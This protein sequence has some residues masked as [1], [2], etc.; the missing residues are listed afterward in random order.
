[1]PRDK[2]TARAYARPTR[3]IKRKASQKLWTMPDSFVCSGFP[4]FCCSR[5]RL[6]QPQMERTLPVKVIIG[7]MEQEHGTV[8]RSPRGLMYS[9]WNPEHV[10]KQVELKS[11]WY[12]RAD[13]LHT[14]CNEELVR[15]SPTGCTA[16]P[17]RSSST[18]KVSSSINRSTIRMGTT[19]NP[20]LAAIHA[21][22]KAY[23]AIVFSK[24]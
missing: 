7:W 23:M 16:G 14:L 20:K 1:M 18:N 21:G 19:G 13:A 10:R 2:G 12:D 3:T 4:A 22:L 8:E 17:R 15:S 24:Q 9:G 5:G 11:V 6:R